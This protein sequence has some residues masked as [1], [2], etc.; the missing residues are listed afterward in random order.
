[1]S[2]DPSAP[3]LRDLYAWRVGNPDLAPAEVL[4]EYD[5]ARAEAY[6]QPVTSSPTGRLGYDADAPKAEGPPYELPWCAGCG[7]RAARCGCPW[8]FAL[9][10]DVLPN[11]PAA[12][13]WL[14]RR[15][16]A[17]IP[18]PGAPSVP[19]V[20]APPAVLLEAWT[21]GSGTTDENPAGIG[22][23]ITRRHVVI[24]EASEHIGNGSNNVAELRAIARALTLARLIA[25]DRAAGLTVR[26]DS[27][28]ALGAIRPGSTWRIRKDALA[29]LVEQMRAEVCRW[30]HLRLEHVKGH[31]GDPGNERADFLAGR[32]R[33][34]AVAARR[35]A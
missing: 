25:G 11:S 18:T 30:P 5:R 7:G 13:A 6:C 35:A 15:R 1:M 23:V 28:F 20:V 26:S 24:C 3:T 33:K 32:A 12:A 2:P 27:E 8:Q 29:D 21:D 14:E 17:G 4:S 22:V 19:P 10:A 9:P 31:A 34:A 16:A